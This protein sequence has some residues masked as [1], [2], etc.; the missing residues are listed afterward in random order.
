METAVTLAVMLIVIAVGA[1]L[2]H[3]LNAQHDERIAGF[4]YSG[5]LPWRD[6]RSRNRPRSALDPA[7]SRLTRNR[8]EQPH[9]D[10]RRLRLF[11]GRRK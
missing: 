3:R 2:I 9:G 11:S 5:V 4:R 10:R 1:F 6:S 7:G 8:H